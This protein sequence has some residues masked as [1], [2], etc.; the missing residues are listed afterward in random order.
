MA[1]YGYMVVKNRCGIPLHIVQVES[2]EFSS[3]SVFNT[4]KDASDYIDYI[5]MRILENGEELEY[6]YDF[7]FAPGLTHIYKT[8]DKLF[9]RLSNRHVYV[10]AIK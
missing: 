7:Q 6:D 4:S 5:K 2:M 3:Y 1:K 10:Y 9:S 8:S